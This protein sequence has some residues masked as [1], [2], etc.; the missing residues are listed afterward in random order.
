MNASVTPRHRVIQKVFEYGG[1]RHNSSHTHTRVCAT[2]MMCC[3]EC[4]LHRN[5]DGCDRCVFFANSRHEYLQVRAPSSCRIRFQ[6]YQT[7]SKVNECYEYVLAAGLLASW[8]TW[9]DD[10]YRLECLVV[11]GNAISLLS[12]ESASGM[13]SCFRYHTG[14]G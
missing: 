13:R 5:C 10:I 12:H 11:G 8:P 9:S 2:V 7:E 3:V 1:T 4:K 6:L 14:C